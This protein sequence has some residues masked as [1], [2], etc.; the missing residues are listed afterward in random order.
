[1]RV[2][3][4]L[5][6]IRRLTDPR[7]PRGPG[8]PRHNG[9]VSSP[10]QKTSAPFTHCGF[11]V[12]A[13]APRLGRH[14]PS[15]CRGDIL[16]LGDFFSSFPGPSR[17]SAA[18]P[19]QLLT[20]ILCPSRR[21]SHQQSS[22]E[23]PNGIHASWPGIPRAS[24]APNAQRPLLRP[25]PC[26]C[27][28]PIPTSCAPYRFDPRERGTNAC[29]HA[30]QTRGGQ[31]FALLGSTN[32]SQLYILGMRCKCVNFGAV[33]DSGSDEK[34][35][36]LL[37]DQPRVVYHRAYLSVRRKRARAH[38]SGEPSWTGRGYDRPTL[39]T[40]AG[41]GVPILNRVPSGKVFRNP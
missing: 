20:R 12:S 5:Q 15:S 33:I 36:R 32:C 30:A 34:R 11:C 17:R 29:P 31:A 10:R 7:G 14:I 27:P 41:V 40:E 16:A 1:M 8:A 21:S 24:C 28:R 2:L 13:L 26:T 6:R 37:W 18:L 9:S 3:A 22:G 38:Q 4:S 23:R 39:H 19:Y 25:R 35:R